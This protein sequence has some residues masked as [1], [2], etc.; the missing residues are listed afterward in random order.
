[1]SEITWAELTEPE[2]KALLLFEQGD[3]KMFSF[4]YH[5]LHAK[6]LIAPV[7]IADDGL[8]D[9]GRA[10]LAQAATPDSGATGA[11]NAQVEAGKVSRDEAIFYRN[12]R[13]DF[14]E[15]EWDRHEAELASAKAEAGRLRAAATRAYN[16]LDTVYE[17]FD[18]DLGNGLSQ[19]IP[20]VCEEIKAALQAGTEGG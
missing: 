2:Q 14:L 13:I 7:D 1:M 20:R 15:K 18:G 8:T 5:L 9:L 17:T 16:C 19:A 10:V 4:E 6:G 3:V 11:K 12:A